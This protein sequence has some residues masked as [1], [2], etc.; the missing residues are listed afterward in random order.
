[1]RI[2]VKQRLLGLF[3]KKEITFG[4]RKDV[5]WVKGIASNPDD[6]H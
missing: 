3:L 4:A 1:M 6:V 5:Q 2:A